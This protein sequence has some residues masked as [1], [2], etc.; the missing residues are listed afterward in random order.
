MI[1]SL[2][3][4]NAY[5]LSRLDEINDNEKIQEGLTEK[6][7]KKEH[8]L[9]RKRNSEIKSISLN[10]D[11]NLENLD[12]EYVHRLIRTNS[13]FSFQYFSTL[14]LGELCSLMNAI[15]SNFDEL[16]KDKKK[17]FTR[18]IKK[19][20]RDRLEHIFKFLDTSVKRK[21]FITLM[22]DEQKAQITIL[23]SNEELDFILE[24]IEDDLTVSK[25]KHVTKCSLVLT[26]LSQ[27]RIKEYF[28]IFSE[29]ENPYFVKAIQEASENK[30]NLLLKEVWLKNPLLLKKVIPIKNF[31]DHQAEF[32]QSLPT[33][34]L[35]WRVNQLD[36]E[37]WAAI[38]PLLSHK[39]L[40]D[41]RERGKLKFRTELIIYSK[42]SY[43]SFMKLHKQDR[44]NPE[45]TDELFAQIIFSLKLKEEIKN[46]FSQISKEI[47][48]QALDLKKLKKETFK[49]KKNKSVLPNSAR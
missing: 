20:E 22:S 27:E 36:H 17:E 38:I 39:T 24:T 44:L 11:F 33:R 31:L 15:L 21:T 4:L 48:S 49:N 23:S 16:E 25:K 43:Q 10:H 30:I 1:S 3:S 37:H 41:L 47:N 45:L 46:Q 14:S 6:K 32:G 2:G 29:S 8:P 35:N 9:K 28:S 26:P 40:K 34:D 5:P 7:S 13:D 12:M 18:S 42:L 19:L